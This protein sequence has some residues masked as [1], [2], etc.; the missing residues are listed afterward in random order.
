MNNNNSA[1]NEPNDSHRAVQGI[2][3]KAILRFIVYILL[4]PLTL[5][6]AAG[7]LDWPEGWM[8]VAFTVV[9]TLLSRIIIARKHPDL[10]AER[11]RYAEAEDAKKWDRTIVALAAIYGPFVVWIVAGLDWRFNWSSPVSTT[12][13]ITAAVILVLGYSVSVW[14]MAVNKFFSAV[15]RIQKDRGHKVVDTGPYRLV[16]HPSYISGM[17]AYIA[18]PVFLDTLWALVPIA[19]VIA[20]TIIRTILEDR[21]L[22]AELDGYRGYAQRVRYRLI[23]G[24]W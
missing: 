9:I 7:S 3:L 22:L 17:L 13:Q 6:L 2:G 20:L 10:L 5:F 23:P 1:A 4:M 8:L 24:V 11:A 15:V 21:T 14:A 16:R 12:W 19:P 18:L